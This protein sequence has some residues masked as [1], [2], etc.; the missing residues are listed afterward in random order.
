MLTYQ[1]TTYHIYHQNAVS[2][3]KKLSLTFRDLKKSES[4][5]TVLCAINSV[6]EDRKTSASALLL[7]RPPYRQI[8]D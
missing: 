4:Y 3:R 6:G 7:P 2:D 8:R 1:L 5:T